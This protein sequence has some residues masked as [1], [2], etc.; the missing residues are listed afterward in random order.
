MNLSGGLLIAGDRIT[1]SSGGTHEHIYP[2]TGQPN[3]S[4]P[5]A[6]A[7]EINE[8]VAAAWDAHRE[9]MSLTADRR[10]DLLIDL[11]DAVHDNLD[12]LARLNV[13]DYAVPISFAHNG[14]LLERFLRHFAGYVD[15]PHGISTP[16]AESFDVNLVEREPYGVVGV[17]TPWNG[18]LVVIGS[19]VA[20][21]LAAGNA[22]VLKPSEVAPFAAL[23]F[24]ELCVAAGLPA[25]LVNVV[26]AGP[27]GGNALVRHPDVRKIH[28]TGGGATARNVLKAAATNLTPVVAELGGKSACVVFD[29][30]DLDA[31]AVLAAHQG[32]LIQ[33]GQSCACASRILVHESVYDAFAERFVAV[34]KAATVGDPLDPGVVFGPVI[35]QAAAD[36]IVAEIEEAAGSKVGELLTGGTRLGGALAAGYYIEPTVFGGVDNNSTLAQTETFGPVVSLMKFGSE[37][38]AARIANDTPYGLNAFVQTR[39]LARAHRMARRLEAGSVWINTFS[40]I[41]PQ[42]PYGGF[43]Q[44][45]FGRTGGVEGLYEFLQVKNIRIGMG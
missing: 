5:L 13:H 40:D 28:F 25:G 8:A 44:S 38:E 16:V 43:K 11:A 37:D 41:S 17:I 15:K 24:G 45:G 30:A 26:P 18:A 29:D 39:D 33:S 7:A 20:P 9:W 36:R 31:A 2:A 34:V 14:I 32:P 21:A 12:E 22:V 35:S 1:R 23:R 42:G 3:A 4:V 10:R 27:E 6:G 19:C